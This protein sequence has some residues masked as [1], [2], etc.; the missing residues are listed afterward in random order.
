MN[1]PRELTADGFKRIYTEKKFRNAVAH[2]HGCCKAAGEKPVFK[3]AFDWPREWAVTDEQ[4]A[5]AK[6][7]IKRACVKTLAENQGKLLLVGMGWPDA[8]IGKNDIGNPRARGNFR[9]P[10]G[11]LC[12]VEI[13]H[14]EKDGKSFLW[15]DFA[16]R[17]N[18]Y[19]K[20]QHHLLSKVWAQG[21]AFSK[22]NILRY[23]NQAF[24]TTFKEVVIDNYDLNADDFE[25]IAAA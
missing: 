7:E 25:S 20:Q 19:E 6:E 23:V 5:E 8:D 11:R 1:T 24:G 15:F 12:F 14:R 2:A 9:D 17:V 3:K 21:A 18:A 16:H 13:N 4:I 10:Q 22:A